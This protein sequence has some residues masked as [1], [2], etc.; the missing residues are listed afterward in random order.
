MDLPAMTGSALI[1]EILTD[2]KMRLENKK[3][4]E[5]GIRFI[6]HASTVTKYEK[7]DITSALDKNNTPHISVDELERIAIEGVDKMK[8]GY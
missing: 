3:Y 6:I 5:V 7:I 4:G 1:N 2:L 8:K